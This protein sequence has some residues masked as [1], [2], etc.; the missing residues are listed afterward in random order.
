MAGARVL[1]RGARRTLVQQQLELERHDSAAETVIAK[2]MVGLV[3]RREAEGT[4]WLRWKPNLDLQDHVWA[5]RG[6]RAE[7]GALAALSSRM[8][9][10]RRV[11]K[12]GCKNRIAHRTILLYSLHQVLSTAIVVGNARAPQAKK[13][14]APS[15]VAPDPRGGWP[16]PQS[17]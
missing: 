16:G 7:R 13:F 2:K 6:R 3:E 11:C 15:R 4:G 9:G 14:F 10:T 5:R 1:G 17:P 12:K 8:P